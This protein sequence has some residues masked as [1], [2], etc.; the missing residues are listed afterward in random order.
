[1]NT[2]IKAFLAA[3][4]QRTVTEA[5][6]AYAKAFSAL[7]DRRYCNTCTACK[8]CFATTSNVLMPGCVPGGRRF[9]GICLGWTARE[10]DDKEI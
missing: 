10:Y 9:A 5:Q 6:R 8:L 7:G 2:K 1:M 3:H 4:R